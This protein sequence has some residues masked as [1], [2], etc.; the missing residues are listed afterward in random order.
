MVL[1][2]KSDLLLKTN[3]LLKEKMSILFF[4]LEG[5]PGNLRIVTRY[6]KVLN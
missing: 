5:V 4:V 6:T 1:R 2:T 3:K